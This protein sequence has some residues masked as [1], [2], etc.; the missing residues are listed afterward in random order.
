MVLKGVGVFVDR[1]SIIIFVFL[2]LLV[3]VCAMLGRF[4]FSLGNEGWEY[5]HMEMEMDYAID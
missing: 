2:F 5:I 3:S 1:F 4:C